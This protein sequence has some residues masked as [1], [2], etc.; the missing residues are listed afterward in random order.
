[1]EATLSIK[2][3]LDITMRQDSLFHEDYPI[4]LC[5]SSLV[6]PDCCVSDIWITGIICSTILILGFFICFFKYM[7]KP[8]TNTESSAASSNEEKKSKIR[9]K[10]GLYQELKLYRSQLA[11]FMEKRTLKKETK[12]I[13]GEEHESISRDY[14]EE[15]S[16]AYIDK[17]ESFIKELTTAVGKELDSTIDETKNAG[18]SSN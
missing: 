9:I 17:L 1:M 12:L 18:T 15:K 16:K 3:T 2:D 5:N 7:A 6:N 8:R 10:E 4:V 11:N 14:D 13:D